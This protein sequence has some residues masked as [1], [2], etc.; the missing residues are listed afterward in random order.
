MPLRT[1]PLRTVAL[2]ATLALGT[3]GA[4]ATDAFIPS[5]ARAQGCGWFAI[6]SCTSQSRGF[7]NNPMGWQVVNTNNVSGFRN[8]LYCIASGPQSRRGANRDRNTLRRRWGISSAYI[9]RGCAS[10]GE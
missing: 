4:V 6:G 2:A 5:D 9:K 3:F 1:M 7:P 8:G 10:F